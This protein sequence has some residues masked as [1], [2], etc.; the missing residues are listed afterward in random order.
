MWLNSMDIKGRGINPFRDPISDHFD[1]QQLINREFIISL[2]SF[3]FDHTLFFPVLKPIFR[4]YC[5]CVSKKA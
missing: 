1:Q 2:A 3:F 5:R 4:M